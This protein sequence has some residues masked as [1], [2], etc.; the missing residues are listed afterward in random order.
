[1]EMNQRLWLQAVWVPRVDSTCQ[2]SVLMPICVCH[3]SGEWTITRWSS[4]GVWDLWTLSLDQGLCVPYQS[5]AC[6]ALLSSQLTF[7]QSSPEMWGSCFLLLGLSFPWCINTCPS[8]PTALSSSK[9]PLAFLFLVLVAKVCPASWIFWLAD[10]K[11]DL[12]IDDSKGKISL[13]LS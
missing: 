7:L 13:L 2:L 12:L 5:L 4:K 10:L 1:M 6:I 3:K 11:W 8:F 9:T